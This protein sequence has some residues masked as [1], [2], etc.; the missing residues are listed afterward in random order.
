MTGGGRNVS[1]GLMKLSK[2]SSKGSAF[3]SPEEV[4]AIENELNQKENQYKSAL[5]AYHEME[6][7]LRRLRDRAPEIDNLVSK[8]N[9]R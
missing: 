9:E 5:D 6:E 1:K 8:L 4:Q 2:S 3:F 7:E